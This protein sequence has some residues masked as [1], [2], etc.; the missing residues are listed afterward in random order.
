MILLCF[1]E[2]WTSVEERLK[3]VLGQLQTEGLKAKLSKYS[4]F[5][6]EVHYLGHVISGEG[7]SANPSKIE[8][9]SNWLIPSTASE[10]WSFLGFAS[11]Y[12][13]FMEGFAK[14][15]APLQ[16]AVAKFGGT[17]TGKKSERGV[18]RCWTDE[19]QQSYQALKTRLYH[20]TNASLC[21]FF[22]PFHSGG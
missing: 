5:Q 18:I 19:C 7:V 22:S 12:Q 4:L 10:L 6:K 15:A 17:K 9:V 3:V 8:V 2:Q 16:K 11:H 20:Y 14:L 13:Y 21:R 1:H